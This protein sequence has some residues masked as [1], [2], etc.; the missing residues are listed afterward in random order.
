MKSSLGSLALATGAAGLISVLA[1]TDVHA[2]TKHY[3]LVWD[4]DGSNSAVI[5]FSPD[6]SSSNP[7]VSY[8]YSTNESS[9]SN[10][11]V[12][13][14]RSFG[15]SIT[16]HFVRLE[17]LTPDSAIYFRVC[18]QNGCGERFWFKTAPDTAEPFVLVAGGDTRTGH[19]TRRQ[20]NQ[21]LA[22]IR[23]LAVM[24][25]GDFTDANSATQMSAFLDDWTLTYSSDQIDGISYKRIYPL[26]PTHGNHE[27]NN[28]STLCQVFGVDFDE[29]GNCNPN[30]TYG[31]VQISPLLRVYTL[32]SQFQNSGWSSYAASMNTWLQSDLSAYGNNSDWR[33]AQYHKPIFPHYTGKSD[34]PTLF[35]WWA[36][37]FYD[38]S[39]NLVVES[40]THLTKLT[41]ALVPSG[42]NFSATGN[43]G[44]VYVGEGSWGAPARSAND[45]K[46][47]TIDL[48]SIQQFKVIQVSANEL[49][50]RTAEFDSSAATLSLAQREADSLLLPANVNWWSANG[51]G[52]T[53]TLNRNGA[54]RSV[55]ASSSG[56]SSSSSS[57]G[58]SG[59]GSSGGGSVQQF[60]QAAS[61]D[62]FIASARAGSNYDGHNDGL[63]ADGSDSYFGKL[64]TLIRFDLSGLENCGNFTSAILELNIT[65]RSSN[66]YGVYQANG[67]WQE[68]TAS[69]NAVG[70]NNVLGSLAATFVPSS[71]G[72]RQIDLL[73]SGMVESWISGGNT[74]LVIAPQSGS[75]GVDMT[76]KETGQGPLL[77]LEA[78]CAN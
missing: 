70:G 36:Q 33:F 55:I 24:H 45:P 39:M 47:W 58:S 7:Y 41:Q 8:G 11:A 16:S 61:D 77:K 23:P 50:V 46:S 13:A 1:A 75:N 71:T 56:G 42:N 26:I 54:N 38:Y 2:A 14:T 52:E 44:T 40:D 48:A 76:S 60:T 49:A 6:G 15:G 4:K 57:G 66:T 73:A 35:N 78:A 9:W 22:K 64:Y 68:N 67:N 27:D 10:V 62:V 59:S 25:G 5:G 43:G 30:D 32:N 37:A 31:A 28:Y 53:L 21:L 3:R 18:D 74:G 69:W 34:N 72:T 51:I 19:T 29:D 12:N 20:G 17:N 63:L 65:D